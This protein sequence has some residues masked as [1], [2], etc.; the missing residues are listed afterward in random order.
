MFYKACSVDIGE[1]VNNSDEGIHSASIGGIWLALVMGFGGVCI[2]D[3]S[4]Y[5]T[6]VLPKGWNK[7]RFTIIYKGTKILIETDSMGSSAKR[8]SG[9]EKEII[10]SGSKLI[11]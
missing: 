2:K 9:D 5:I 8:L 11:V 10:L 4:L 1:E 3:G 6:P 7:Y